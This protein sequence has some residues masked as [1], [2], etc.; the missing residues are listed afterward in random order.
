MGYREFSAEESSMA[1]KHLKSCSMFLVIREVK[2]IMSL[3]F[4]LI[5]V[6]MTTMKN[7]HDSTCRQ[8][9]QQREGSIPPLLVGVQTSKITF[10]INLAVSQKTGN[11]SMS[12]TRYLIPGYIYTKDVPLIPQGH[13]LNYVHSNFICNSQKLETT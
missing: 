11:S 5:Q 1:E 13:L 3:S 2:I 4:H 9:C 8:G 7:S 12:R 10:E 6:R